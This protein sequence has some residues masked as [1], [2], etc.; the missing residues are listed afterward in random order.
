MNMFAYSKSE[1][2][3]TKIDQAVFDEILQNMVMKQRQSAM[4]P[5]SNMSDR[6]VTPD[7]F[8]GGRVISNLDPTLVPPLIENPG[9]T[10][11]DFSFYD[12]FKKHIDEK[13]ISSIIQG[14][15]PQG[16]MT[17]GQYMDQQKRSYMTLGSKL[18]GLLQWEK[19]MIRLRVM[20]LLAHSYQEDE[21][22]GYKSISMED[23]MQDGSK[24]MNVVNFESPNIKT[25]E[26]IFQE[27]IEYEKANGAQVAY[28]YIDPKLMKAV[29]DD[30]DYY[31]CYEVIPV[32]KN[33]DTITQMTFVAMITQAQ[34]LFGPESIA[35]DNLKKEYARV[36]NKA[37]DDLFLNPQELQAKQQA[38]QQAQMNNPTAKGAV[39]SPYVPN[40]PAPANPAAPATPNFLS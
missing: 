39:K 34:N 1:P 7:M 13:S 33:N 6:I 20:N 18:D 36:M 35:V 11:A 29:L 12:L 40:A 31:I 25:S 16:N 38:A 3:K 27:E 24:G 30:P 10:Q 15:Q 2:S 28:T 32:D 5:R 14:Q 4:V 8:L 26:D 17:L 22:G 37:Y 23:S 9:I 21:E 19:Q